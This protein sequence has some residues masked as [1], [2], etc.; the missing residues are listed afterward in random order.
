MII[1][2]FQID[3]HRRPVQADQ[4]LKIKFA[5]LSALMLREGVQKFSF[6][7]LATCLSSGT[8]FM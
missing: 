6:S 1:R 5:M 7:V 2:L 4:R 3:K 8:E